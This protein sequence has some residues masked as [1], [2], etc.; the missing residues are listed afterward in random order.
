MKLSSFSFDS[1]TKQISFSP[2]HSLSEKILH[3]YG[4][5]ITPPAQK[6]D[7]SSTHLVVFVVKE[8]IL[9]G[10]MNGNE[11]EEAVFEIGV[12][13]PRRIIQEKDESC[14]CAYVLV[15][16]FKKVGFVVERIIGIADEFIKLAAPLETL[17]RAAAELQIKKRTHIG[18]N[19]QFEVE[20]VEAFAKQP[21]GSVFSWCE[22][23]HCYC[24]LIY[25]IVNNSKSAI[26]LKFDGKEIYWETGENLIQKLESENI[27]KQVFPLHDEKTRKKLLRTWALHWWDFTS[28][29]ID[30]IYSYYG[31]KYILLFL[32]C[33]HDGCSSSLHLVLHCN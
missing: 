30:E 17:G 8:E 29:P 33:T 14:D 16:E 12:V 4:I 1:L 2:I 31:A 7:L 23:F 18:M 13:I 6:T 3:F 24:H 19:L 22:R 10:K 20:E 28:Q 11:N 5:S 26:T 21:D 15:E 27:V 9:L 25:G 32:E